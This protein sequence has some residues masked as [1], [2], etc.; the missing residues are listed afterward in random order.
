MIFLKKL[1]SYLLIF[2]ILYNCALPD[3]IYMR[4]MNRLYSRATSKNGHFN[5]GR[6]LRKVLRNRSRKSK[7]GSS[8]SQEVTKYNKSPLFISTKTTKPDYCSVD[9]RLRQKYEKSDIIITAQ[10]KD[11]YGRAKIKERI[12]IH[13]YKKSRRKYKSAV[14]PN[15]YRKYKSY[16]PYTGTYRYKASPRAVS[17]WDILDEHPKSKRRKESFR[18]NKYGVSARDRNGRRSKYKHTNRNVYKKPFIKSP[19]IS[20]L[21]QNPVISNTTIITNNSLPKT[22]SKI[23]I[24]TTSPRKRTYVYTEGRLRRI[25]ED[26][27]IS[28]RTAK[29]KTRNKREVASSS[30]DRFY[31]NYNRKLSKNYYQHRK[32]KSKIEKIESKYRRRKVAADR[33]KDRRKYIMMDTVLVWGI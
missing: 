18:K 14:N 31:R 17:I 6:P 28:A 32:L 25:D 2:S 3:S 19:K 16:D 24:S 11:I 9:P 13:D 23:K 26:Q 21:I 5:Y 15:Y 4:R 10:V 7:F 20:E 8:S 12:T 33:K 29:Q 1:H 22:P 27:H 30:T